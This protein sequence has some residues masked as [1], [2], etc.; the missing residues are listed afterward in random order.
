[1]SKIAL[2]NYPGANERFAPGC[3]DHNIGSE[4]PIRLGYDSA[5]G[6]LLEASVAEDGTYADLVLEVSD[7][8]AAALMAGDETT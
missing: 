2:R 7:E 6:R 1:M 8:V 3:F 5:T 4:V